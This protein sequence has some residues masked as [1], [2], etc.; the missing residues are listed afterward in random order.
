VGP[1]KKTRLLY[2]ADPYNR[3]NFHKYIDKHRHI[4]FICKTIYG[5]LI[6]GYSEEAFDPNGIKRGYGM[7]LSLWAKKVF[8]IKEKKAIAYDDYFGIFGN[9]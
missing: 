3:T 9:S 6:A 2:R 8:E 4:V 7:I 1:I 5:K